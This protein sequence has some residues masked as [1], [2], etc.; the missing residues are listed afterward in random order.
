M[1][2]TIWLL[3]II[4]IIDIVFIMFTPLKYSLFTQLAIKIGLALLFYLFFSLIHRIFLKIFKL[5]YKA[6]V[7]AATREVRLSDPRIITVIVVSCIVEFLILFVLSNYADQLTTDILYFSVLILIGVVIA[8]WCNSAWYVP[9]FTATIVILLVTTIHSIMFYFDPNL[10]S[11]F[12]SQIL[13]Y[14]IIN[15]AENFSKLPIN[16][17]VTWISWRVLFDFKKMYPELSRKNS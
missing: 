2:L 13:T 4:G 1:R 6:I 3:S 17:T 12:G 8:L 10:N 5:D 16:I 11:Q 14:T 7:E 9:V 15:Q